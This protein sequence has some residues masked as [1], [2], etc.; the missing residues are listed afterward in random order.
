[1]S[2]SDLQPGD[3]ITS[4]DGKPVLTVHQL[5]DEVSVKKPG[6][7]AVLDVVRGKE[8]LT[9]KV[10]PSVMPSV[11]E[12][13][14]RTHRPHDAV[15]PTGLGLTVQGLT[16]ELAKQYG[17]EV[18]TGVLVTAV[19]ENSPAAMQGMKPGDVITAINRRRVST[20]GQFRDFVKSADPKRGLMVNFVS[21]GESRFLVLK[22]TGGN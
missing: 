1:M 6:R 16:K 8:H 2:K 15:E 5:R 19:E 3:V 9:I 14:A 18:I 17:V 12:L 11:N 22:E 7:M 21:E 10:A 20:P 13:A 4:V